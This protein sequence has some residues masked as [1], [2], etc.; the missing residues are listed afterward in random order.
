MAHGFAGERT[1]RLPAF[2]Q[3]F[4][5]QG[6]AVFLFDYRSFGGSEGS[7]R[8]QVNPNQQLADWR[9]AIAHVRALPELRGSRLALWGTSFSGGHV[10]SIAAQDGAIDAIIAQVPFVSGWNLMKGQSL[11]NLVQLTSAAIMD[12]MAALLGL[13]PVHYP[14]VAKPGSRAIMNTP[15]SY[16]GYLQ[17][18]PPQTNWQNAVPARVGLHIPFYSPLSRAAQ[19]KCPSLIIAARND[20][21][22]PVAAVKM[23]AERIPGADY[24]EL[25]TDH[26]QPYV[27]PAFADNIAIQQDFLAKHILG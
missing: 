5:R 4:C 2:A 27:E 7:P 9:A 15:E 3:A 6:V 10:I 12:G 16:D 13:K 8:Q 17:L 18:A 20:S 14:V 21:L 1:F 22:I 24:R 11:G 19:V 25:D 23:L 26:F